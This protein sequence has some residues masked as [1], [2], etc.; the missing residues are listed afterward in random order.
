[1][2][3]VK[4]TV[5]LSYRRTNIPWA[6]NLFQ[7]LTHNGYDVFFDY[8]GIASGDF[9]RIISSRRRRLRAAA[10]LPT[11]CGAKLKPL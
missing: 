4:K 9:E 7:N 5:F 8:S 11:G 2:E 1:M 6:L 3:N 10:T